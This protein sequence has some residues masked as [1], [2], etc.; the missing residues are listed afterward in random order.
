M[1]Q[2]DVEYILWL[3]KR[4]VYRYK[5]DENIID[6]VEHILKLWKEEYVKSNHHKEFIDKHINILLENIAKITQYKIC[7]NEHEPK[8][9]TQSISEQSNSQIHTSFEDL[10]LNDIF[11]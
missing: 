1:K 11:N 2:E 3:S 4:L 9:V 5:E 6:K 8:T 7:Y 10:D